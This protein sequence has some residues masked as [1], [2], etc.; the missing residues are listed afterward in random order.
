MRICLST[1]L[2]IGV[3]EEREQSLTALVSKEFAC[4]YVCVAAITQRCVPVTRKCAPVTQKC[5]TITPKGVPLTRKCVP[6]T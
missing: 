2:R 6:I 5:I 1:S 4:A 3:R